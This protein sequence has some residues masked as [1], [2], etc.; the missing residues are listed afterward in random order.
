MTLLFGCIC[1]LLCLYLVD[2]RVFFFQFLHHLYKISYKSI[3]WAF[4]VLKMLLSHNM[5]VCLN[6]IESRNYFLDGVTKTGYT[7]DAG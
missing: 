4:L 1:N 2:K 7:I 3:H 5:H 6:M